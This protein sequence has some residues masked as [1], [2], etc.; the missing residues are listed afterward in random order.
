MLWKVIY[1]SYQCNK[2][3]AS[4]EK[5]AKILQNCPRSRYHY[6]LF[7]KVYSFACIRPAVN[8][9][10]EIVSMLLKYIRQPLHEHT[11]SQYW[12]QYDNST[13]KLLYTTACLTRRV[14]LSDRCLA[15]RQEE[16]GSKIFILY[17]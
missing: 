16:R 12:C 17:Y 2:A 9:A 1:V 13:V 11:Y 4:M 6:F 10:Q 3:V 14:A 5:S 8:I 7:K 15:R